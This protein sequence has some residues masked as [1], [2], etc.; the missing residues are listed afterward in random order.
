MFFC[1]FF[2]CAFHSFGLKAKNAKG[3]ST[4]NRRG[5]SAFVSANDQ[6]N[7]IKNKAFRFSKKAFSRKTINGS[8]GPNNLKGRLI[9]L[10]I[11]WIERS[12]IKLEMSCNNKI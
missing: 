10:F 1:I 3:T 12:F 7:V 4:E 2:K 9:F 6:I 8:Y 5:L 11:F